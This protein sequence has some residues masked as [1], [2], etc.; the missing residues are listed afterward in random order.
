LPEWL[1]LANEWR[2]VIFGGLLVLITLFAPAGLAGL[3]HALWRR[4]S[5]S[6]G[7]RS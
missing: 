6:R 2:L 7:G 5:P 1:R 4:L 3:L